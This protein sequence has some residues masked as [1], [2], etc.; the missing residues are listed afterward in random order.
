RDLRN[1]AD[2][3]RKVDEKMRK[4]LQE[5][6]QKE[7]DGKDRKAEM[8]R[9][10]EMLKGK[11][12]DKRRIDEEK[13]RLDAEIEKHLRDKFKNLERKNVPQPPRPPGDEMRELQQ[14]LER[15]LR[16]VEDLRRRID[17]LPQR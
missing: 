9:L 8:E 1:E 4:H 2:L 15:A 3:R 11:E 12:A 17:K 13:R 16:E 6:L 14:R 10:M 7:S 5:Q